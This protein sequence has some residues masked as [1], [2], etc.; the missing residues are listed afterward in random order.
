MAQIPSETP[1]LDSVNSTEWLI[2][3][4]SFVEANSVVRWSSILSTPFPVQQGVKQGSI[5]GPIE[6]KRYNNP[7]LNT[8]ENSG[9]GFRFGEIACPAPTCADDM[10][11][12]ANSAEDLKLLLG[13]VEDFSIQERYDIQATKSAIIKVNHKDQDESFTIRGEVIPVVQETKHLGLVR[14]KNLNITID[15]FWASQHS[16][17][18]SFVRWIW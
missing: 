15:P 14:S 4:N 1:I 17:S 18:P 7:L 9:L 16:L 10:A 6:Y 13:I 2:I 8:L 3:Q 5:L 11:L 12:L